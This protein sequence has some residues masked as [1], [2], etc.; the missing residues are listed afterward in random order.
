MISFI[1]GEL[2]EVAEGH[3]VV[4]AGGVGFDI[5]VPSTLSGELPGIGEE[6]KIYTHLRVGEDAFSLYGFTSGSDRKLFEQLIGVNGIG[7]KGALS[8]LSALGADRFR[9]AILEGDAKLIATAPGVGMKTAQ[10]IILDLKDKVDIG[11]IIGKNVSA[12][13]DLPGNVEDAIEALVALGYPAAQAARAVRS[14]PD[15]RERETQEIIRL[16]LMKLV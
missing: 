16:A 13:S 12:G 9:A 14:I 8:I 7:P 10:R 6:V 1:R 4:D 15:A 3:I 2:A 5:N 11:S